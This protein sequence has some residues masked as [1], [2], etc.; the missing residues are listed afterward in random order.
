LQQDGIPVDVLAG[1]LGQ[2]PSAVGRAFGEMLFADALDAMA[3]GMLELDATVLDPV[4]EGSMQ[5]A[6]DPSEPIP[7]PT[8]VITAD[9]ASPDCVARTAD[10]EQLVATTPHA[11]VSVQPG[12]SHLVHDELTHRDAFRAKVR[13]FLDRLHS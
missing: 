6:Y 13:S 11:E 3:G 2:A 4:L 8:L 7:V 9:P 10:V 5:P 12:A 1:I